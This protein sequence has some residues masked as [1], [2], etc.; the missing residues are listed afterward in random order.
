MTLSNWKSAFGKL[1]AYGA[2]LL[3]FDEVDHLGLNSATI[4]DY[5]SY[6]TGGYVEAAER[7]IRSVQIKGGG[8]I[9]FTSNHKWNYK[10]QN[11]E[12]D[13]GWV[14]RFIFLP[15]YQFGKK[16]KRDPN[17]ENSLVADVSGLINWGMAVQKEVVEDVCNNAQVFSNYLEQQAGLARKE[18]KFL[19]W[20]W[21]YAS[22]R[23]EPSSRVFAGIKEK[24]KTIY[25]DTLYYDYREYSENNNLPWATPTDFKN[26]ME[27]LVQSL[28]LPNVKWNEQK[29]RSDRGVY[30]RGVTLDLNVGSP[31]EERIP[32]VITNLKNFSLRTYRTA[33][34]PFENLGIIK[35]S[36]FE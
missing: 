6:I 29:P 1:Q 32:E 35:P 4:S 20:E 33:D 3:I 24:E 7:H 18:I 27:D 9:I 34:H 25:R 14:R 21:F 11:L 15:I 19:V 31:I 16:S 12:N 8:L 26:I 17:L 28:D 22:V 13:S 2:K 30:L 5:K 36:V 23:L 10:K